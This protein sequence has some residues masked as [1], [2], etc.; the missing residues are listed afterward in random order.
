MKGLLVDRL[1]F[2]RIVQH[3]EGHTFVVPRRF[4]PGQSHFE[5]YGRVE[6]NGEELIEYREKDDMAEELKRA[7]SMSEHL[8]GE[9]RRLE[10]IVRNL[11]A[12]NGRLALDLHRGAS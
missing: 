6:R 11:E 1:G 2:E 5:W 7:H 10:S 4:G 9:V 3:A 8:R 12:E